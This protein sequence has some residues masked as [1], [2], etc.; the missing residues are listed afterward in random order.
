[1]S[2]RNPVGFL[3]IRLVEEKLIDETILQDYRKVHEKLERLLDKVARPIDDASLLAVEEQFLA[4]LHSH[5]ARKD[6][7]E[8]RTSL[9]R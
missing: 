7:E 8:R 1:M 2:E 4:W 3:D 5:E 9:L 6:E